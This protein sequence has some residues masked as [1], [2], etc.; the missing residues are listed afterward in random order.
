MYDYKTGR[1]TGVPE[2]GITPEE[3]ELFDMTRRREVRLRIIIGILA[4]A[5]IL[6]LLRSLFRG[7]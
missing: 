2:L 6:L 3:E 5:V 4:G 1:Y 7:L